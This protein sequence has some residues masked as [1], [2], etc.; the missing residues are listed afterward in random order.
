M[1]DDVPS[2]REL[3]RRLDDS[4]AALT[5]RLL[6]ISTECRAGISSAVDV[7]VFE[8]D[9]RVRAAERAADR[10]YMERIA[11]EL[12]RQRERTTAAWRLGF[13]AIVGPVVVALIL[14][15]VFGAQV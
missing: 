14:W 15:I 6:D 3:W 13:S 7:R 4:E 10:Q 5:R 8:A 12:D 1:Q 9:Q 2:V 11:E